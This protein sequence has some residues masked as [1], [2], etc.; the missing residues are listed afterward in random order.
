VIEHKDKTP[1]KK[2]LSEAISCSLNS[3]NILQ[4]YL[5][6]SRLSIDNNRAELTIKLFVIG[7]KA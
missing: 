1:A 2:E 6:D 7:R 5:E 4:R 3:S